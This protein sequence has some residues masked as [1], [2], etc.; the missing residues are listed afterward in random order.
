MS[1]WQKNSV[2]FGT[3]RLGQKI[4]KQSAVEKQSFISVY[5]REL[6]SVYKGSKLLSFKASI[7][8]SKINNISGTFDIVRQK[9][10]SIKRLKNESTKSNLNN[11]LRENCFIVFSDAVKSTF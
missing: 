4:E 3:V 1:F 5:M 7:Y 11:S 10:E 9:I 6:K 2:F 8:R